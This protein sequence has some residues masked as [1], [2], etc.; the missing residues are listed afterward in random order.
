MVRRPTR[1]FRAL[2]ACVALLAGAGCSNDD[3]TTV[4]DP[5]SVQNPPITRIMGRAVNASSGV[6]VQGTVT[7]CG[8]G[9]TATDA[10]GVFI[11][12]IVGALDKG[13]ASRLDVK[14]EAQ[15]LATAETVGRFRNVTG[16]SAISVGV[17]FGGPASGA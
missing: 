15:G 17:I 8:F 1:R 9:Q 5:P 16:G 14:I 3:S 10:N 2:I 12:D 6:P 11:F 7:V 4:G 13:E